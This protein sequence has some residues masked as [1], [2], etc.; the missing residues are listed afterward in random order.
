MTNNIEITTLLSS[1]EER[2]GRPVKSPTD[3]DLLSLRIS[4]TISE[5]ISS[6]TLKR[7]YGYISTDHTPRYSTL[8]TLSRFVGY[9]DWDDFRHRGLNNPS[10]ESGFLSCKQIDTCNLKIG[11]RIELCWRPN[12]RCVIIY[13]GNNCF[14]IEE[15]Y[16]TKIVPGDTFTALSFMLGHPLYISDLKHGNEE[17][18]SYVAGQRYGLS[19][20]S[21]IKK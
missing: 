17:P 4:E 6:T 20:L 11:D 12:R 15:A 10:A 9:S 2:L 21:L 7:L 3:F 14:T 16:R 1:I 18:R 5:H 19:G 13:N 8:S